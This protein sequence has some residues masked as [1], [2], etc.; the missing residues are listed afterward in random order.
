MTK[1][2]VDIAVGRHIVSVA[3]KVASYNR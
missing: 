1:S 2:L 3:A